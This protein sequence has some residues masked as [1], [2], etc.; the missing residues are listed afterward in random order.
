MEKVVD[1]GNKVLSKE[2]FREDFLP[3]FADWFKGWLGETLVKIAARLN[4]PKEIYHPLHNITLQ[5]PDGTTQ[6][7]HVFVSPFGIFVLETKH[8]KG[9]IF[10][11][12]KQANWTQ[13]IY[14][15]SF[16][17]QNPLRQ[18]Y[19]HTEA[20]K[21][22]LNL[23]NDRVHS[24][25]TFT[26]ACYF[27][28]DMPANVTIGG[29]YTR[30]IKS[31]QES[32]FSDA[33]VAKMIDLLTNARLANNRATHK[34][35]VEDLQKRRSDKNQQ[36]CPKCGSDMVLREVKKGPRTGQPFWGCSDFPKC[37]TTKPY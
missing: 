7:D 13:K 12:E 30:Y 24:V 11:S 1:Y 10:G 15:R 21:N 22:T 26:G 28:T 14:K 35:H 5:T 3:G 2:F 33:E 27:K 18:N 37:R 9:W 32:V 20:I 36:L 31:F 4:L 29:H 16:K 8:M 17:F 34:A 19:K 6:I 23:E 25:I